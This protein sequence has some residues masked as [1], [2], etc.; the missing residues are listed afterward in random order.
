MPW[1]AHHARVGFIPF[2]DHRTDSSNDGKMPYRA[3][4]YG[5]RV[6]ERDNTGGWIVE[7]ETIGDLNGAF[8]FKAGAQR[9]PIS[10]WSFAWASM[11]DE[12]SSGTPTPSTPGGVNDFR[13]SGGTN[14]GSGGSF[15]SFGSPSGSFASL[16]R[17]GG[18]LGT[19]VASTGAGRARGSYPSRVLPMRR[20]ASTTQSGVSL[21]GSSAPNYN[22]DARFVTESLQLDGPWPKFLPRTPGIVTS[23]VNEGAQY[24]VF[25]PTDP[26]LIANHHGGEP[27]HASLV[28][29]LKNP[30]AIDEKRTARLHGLLRVIAGPVGTSSS[31]SFRDENLLALQY[32]PT[33]L[34]S[35][36]GYGAVYDVADLRRGDVTPR[37]DAG[38]EYYHGRR[39][40]TTF[41]PPPAGTRITIPIVGG[42]LYK[43]GGALATGLMS[44]PGAAGP[45]SVGSENDIHRHGVDAD[46]KVINAGHLSSESYFRIPG[47]PSNAFDGPFRFVTAQYTGVLYPITTHCEIRWDSKETHSFLGQ[48]KVGR[49][50]I[51]ATA[52]VGG[53]SS[54]P[55][56]TP[57]TTP[58]TPGRPPVTPPIGPPVPPPVTPPVTTP[59]NPFP[60]G[61]QPSYSESPAGGTTLPVLSRPLNPSPLTSYSPSI[62]SVSVALSPFG[63]GESGRGLP[64]PATSS[65]VPF[66]T[67]PGSTR[68]PRLTG[69]WEAADKPEDD[70]HTFQS[71]GSPAILGRPPSLNPAHPNLRSAPGV[72]DHQFTNA[73]A[74]TPVSIRIEA[75]AKQ[76]VGG[77]WSYAQRPGLARYLGG[78]APGGFV[79]LPP[80]LSIDDYARDFSVPNLTPSTTYFAAVP[81]VYFGAGF[82][83]PS[84]G[85][86]KTGYR[87]GTTAA[88]ALSFEQLDSSGAATTVLKLNESKALSFREAGG[89]LVAPVVALSHVNSTTTVGNTAAET[90]LVS[91]SIPGGTLG[92]DRTLRLRVQGDFKQNNSRTFVLRIKYG[93]TTVY[94]SGSVTIA[95]SANT[96]AMELVVEFGGLGSTAVQHGWGRFDIGSATNPTTGTSDLDGSVSHS[97]FETIN[98]SEDSTTTLTLKVTIQWSAADAATQ[99]RSERATLEV[100]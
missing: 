35:I 76:I 1:L 57:V 96:R 71:I 3:V 40:D 66:I 68:T 45:V 44:S 60:A 19:T 24:G 92:T 84:T 90:D 47:A 94:A 48:T 14:F 91:F 43:P 32:A 86:M 15:S 77:E 55:K 26:R 82:P 93:A 51:Q 37:L 64:V 85:G 67:K 4:W 65:G 41:S 50:H 49:W 63:N 10:G 52:P 53:T 78:T 73:E 12:S 30:A 58:S 56:K 72:A 20:G 81:G 21:A 36:G 70:L 80:E 6:V 13:T 74:T 69:P 22:P 27:S 23:V 38:E 17:A 16:S 83:V 28:C 99:I 54:P 89:T 59:S 9:R 75:F 18:G 79:V 8:L 5:A 31:I 7:P 33:D 88:G 100:G 98:S 42:T 61:I 95:N 46:G 25:L 39:T 29:D 97:N 62:D 87:W 2:Q 11:V 34:D